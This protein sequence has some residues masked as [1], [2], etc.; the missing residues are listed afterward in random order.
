MLK[1]ERIHDAIIFLLIACVIGTCV[2]AVRSAPPPPLAHHNQTENDSHPDHK[3]QPARIVAALVFI[4]EFLERNN[5]AITALA[6]ILLAV[7]TWGLVRSGV[8]QQ[9][10]TRAQLRAYVL[11]ES[12]SVVAADLNGMAIVPVQQISIGTQPIVAM[13]WR[14]FGPT[15]TSDVE[16]AGNVCLT[17]WPID[18]ATFPALDREQGSRQLLGPNT[19]TMKYEIAE[20]PLILSPDNMAGL[21]NGTLA[22]VA[23]GEVIYRDVFGRR[24]WTKYRYFTGGPPGVRGTSMSAHDDGNDAS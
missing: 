4:G 12:V 9:N 3:D 11:P 2:M 8:E 14:N 19:T 17:P 22:F 15:P 5:G 20:I 18:S 16:M 13:A 23:F 6:T 1:R 21:Q 7:I 10:T 24:Q